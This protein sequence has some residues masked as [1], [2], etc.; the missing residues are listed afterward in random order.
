MSFKRLSLPVLK[1]IYSCSLILESL[2]NLKL[3]EY[4]YGYKSCSSFL[5]K[6]ASSS[7]FGV[8]TFLRL[9]RNNG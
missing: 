2:T 8:I 4:K 1:Q 7:Y 6:I 9:S 5:A 3:S